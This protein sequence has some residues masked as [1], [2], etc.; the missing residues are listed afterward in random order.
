MSG[1]LEVRVLGEV[2]I[3]WGDRELPPFESARAESLLAYLLLHRG[4]PQPREWL[5]FMLWPDSSEQQARTNLRHVLHTL[6]GALPE[7]ERFL[8]VTARTLCWRPDAPLELDVAEFERALAGAEGSGEQD[9][10]R[11]AIRAYSG[12]LLVGRYDEWVLVERERLRDRY[13]GALERLASLLEQTGELAGAIEH[14]ERVLREDPLREPAARLLMR[15][16]DARGDGAQAMRAYHACAAALRRELGTPPSAATRA[17]YEALL[18][19]VGDVGETQPPGSAPLVGRAAERSRLTELWRT[20]AR[21]HAQLALV[22]GEPGVGKTRLVEELGAWCERHGALLAQARAYQAEGAL[23]F[24]LVVAWLRAPAI[25]AGIARL[26]DRD[27]AELGRLVPELA[28]TPGALGPLPASERRRRLFEA[29]GRA[30]VGSGRRIVL[31]ADDLQ[32]ADQESLQFLHHLLRSEGEAPVLVL[33]T[34][35]REHVDAGHRLQQLLT[36]LP[37]IDRVTELELERLSPSETAVLAEHLRGHA[38]A[39]DRAARLYAD[40]E[41]NPLFVVEALHAGWSDKERGPVTPRVQAVIQ[42]RLDELSAPACE[43]IGLAAAVGREFTAELLFAAAGTGDRALTRDLDELWR[44]GLVRE[45]GADAYDFSHDRIREVAEQ[46]LGPARRREAHLRIA[47]AL[48][49]R[50]AQNPGRAGAQIAAHYDRA[51]A[52][53][54]AVRW[55]VEAAQAAQRMHADPEAIRLLDRALELAI[56]E[57]AELD[58]LMAQLAPLIDVEGA[59]SDRLTQ[60]Q[61]RAM[62]LATAI[63]VEPAPPLLRSMAV[64]GLSQGR[65]ADARTAGERLL[66]AGRRSGDDV[67]VTEAH[68]VLGIAAFWQG[69]LAEARDQFETAVRSCR[70]EHR[71]T[72]MFRYGLHPE[73]ICLSRLANTR[74]LLGDPIGAG[75]ACDAAIALAEE[76][77]HPPT[78]DTVRVFAALLSLDLGD[79]AGLRHHAAA[80]AADRR[81]STRVTRTSAAALAGYVDVLEGDGATGLAR[82]AAALEEVQHAP[83][84]HAGIVRIQLE[85]CARLGDARAGSEAAALALGRGTGTRPWEPE[86]RRL[87][88]RFLAALGAPPEDVEAELARAL[89]VAREQGSAA[90]EQRVLADLA[91]ERSWNAAGPMLGA[92]TAPQGDG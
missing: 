88:A 61:R 2:R 39:L 63:G 18:P 41:G 55:Y 46:G 10:L 59:V 54:D 42:A 48:E 76:L 70:A 11:K 12:D 33:G 85:A 57:R 17:A 13:L 7:P 3:R 91:G 23:A 53:S 9:A 1:R 40:T 92:Q 34:A 86:V 22:M 16:H 45:Q 60:V 90:L 21:G 37:G 50:H 52:A 62:E 47:R 87:R 4:A 65:F 78:I 69:E 79:D 83:G 84:M 75:K 28:G 5:A 38:L 14:A 24:G 82:I 25:A 20:S 89:D 31:I 58:L 49:H 74:W 73:A 30:L 35:R 6:R 43:L 67:S 64:T 27:R 51:G 72:H 26:G 71:A 8:E 68:Y 56:G 19:G 81:P 77:A 15:L 66:A 32:W 44:R 80:H 29:V 36:G